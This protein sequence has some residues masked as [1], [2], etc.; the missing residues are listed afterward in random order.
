VG[1]SPSLTALHDETAL[2]RP[3]RSGRVPNRS[4]LGQAAG[5]EGRR[6]RSHGV[7]GEA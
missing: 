6:P 1:R 5:D 7:K 2:S 4:A 3:A